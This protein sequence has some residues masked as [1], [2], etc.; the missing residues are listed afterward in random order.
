M[1]RL[2]HAF[3]TLAISVA[4]GAAGHV[5][6]P[7]Y[8]TFDSGQ[9]EALTRIS[10]YLNS[11]RSLKGGFVQVDPDGTVEEGEFYLE[12]PGRMRFEYR[13]PAPTLIVSD[14]R[15]VAVRNSKLNT[16]DRYPLSDTPL[17]L[18]LGDT[19]DLQHNLSVTGLAE[20]Q[21]EWIVHARSASTRTQGDIA[22]TFAAEP[23][24]LRQWTV[25]DSQ[26]LSTTVALRNVET[27]VPLSGSLF[28]LSDPKSP[29]ARKSEE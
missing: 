21:G 22:I 8:A 23:L 20:S 29:F 18:I 16:V 10:G 28:V 4:L 9:K 7:H 1:R 24:E 15:T 14:G 2:V 5:A 19:I 27:G 11:I 6:P 13:P 26:G 12:K 3:F 17:D 25:V